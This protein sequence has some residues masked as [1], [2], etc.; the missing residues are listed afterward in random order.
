MSP[1]KF[2][3]MLH[4][5]WHLTHPGQDCGEESMAVISDVGLQQ[6]MLYDA[7]SNPT[8]VSPM[9]GLP[10]MSSDVEEME[11]R[12]HKLRMET[13]LPVMPLLIGQSDFMGA[14]AAVLHIHKTDDDLTPEQV[15]AVHVVFTN[16][17]KASVVASVSTAVS[18]GVLHVNKGV[19]TTDEQ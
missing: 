9:M 12:A 16:I 2:V 6:Q 19:V 15:E 1:K 13:I 10:A 3:D 7:F 14:C 8:E 5:L 4:S 17:I 18:L 11:Q